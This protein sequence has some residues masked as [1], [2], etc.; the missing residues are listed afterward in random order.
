[1]FFLSSC[2]CLCQIRWN[3][4][5]SREWRCSWSRA[6]RRC[7]N[8]IWVINNVIAHQGAP[9]IRVLT[10]FTTFWIVCNNLYKYPFIDVYSTLLFHK[11]VFLSRIISFVDESKLTMYRSPG[12]NMA[13]VPNSRQLIGICGSAVYKMDQDWVE[14]GAVWPASA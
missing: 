1:M 3:Q 14:R 4:V 13:L 2:S 8:Y 11:Y 9:Y 7:P 12:N 5:L 10:V 6:D